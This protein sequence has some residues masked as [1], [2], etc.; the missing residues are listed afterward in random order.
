MSS[1]RCLGC[2]EVH[3]WMFILGCIVARIGLELRI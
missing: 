1:E 2:V 3:T